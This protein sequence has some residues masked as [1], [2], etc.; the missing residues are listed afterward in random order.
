MKRS[1]PLYSKAEQRKRYAGDA[2][3]ARMDV[4]ALQKAAGKIRWGNATRRRAA[5]KQPR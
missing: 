1:K 4:D 2:A 5:P 3:L